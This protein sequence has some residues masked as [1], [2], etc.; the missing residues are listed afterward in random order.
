METAAPRSHP[1]T[2]PSPGSPSPPAIKLTSSI[3]DVP[4]VGAKRAAAFAKLGI[5][6]VA[7]L[8]R[9]IPARYEH[10]LSEQTIAAAGRSIGDLHGAEA[11][12]AVRGEVGAARAP[13]PGSRRAPFQATLFDGT[14][15]VKLTWFNA[16]WMRGKLHPGMNILV[17]GKAKRHGDYIEMVN[18]KWQP[19]NGEQQSRRSDRLVPVYPASEALPSAAIQQAVDHVLDP[20]LALLEDHLH[21][22]Y[23]RAA[24]L[25]ALADAYRMVHHP[26]DEEEI[27][28]GQ[29][30]LALDELLMLQ[31]GVMLKRHHRQRSLHAP[32]LR[33]TA[34]INQ[35]IRARFPFKLTAAQDSVIK[36]IVG[37][38]QR[39]TPMNRLIQ[40][41]VG[42]GKTIVALYAMLMARA[43][44]HQ[45]ALM[46][47]T[48]ILAE[49]HFQSMTQM[50]KGSRVTIE[51]L[52]GSLTPP[53]R[54]R[55][56]KGVE[57]GTIHILIGTHALLSGGVNF[58]SLALAVIDEQHR[59][60]VHQRATLRTKA[61]DPNSIP[62]TLVMTATPIP[63]TLSLT[64]FGDLDI[65]TIQGLPP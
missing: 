13:L 36:Q 50:L 4:G 22:A 10:Q 39:A 32:P 55:I 43:S 45:A 26:A 27:K 16:P 14:G 57:D 40:G 34:Q 37:D 35:R 25:P 15:T 44:G 7:D 41:D 30:R 21:E 38:L 5:R 52:T 3:A 63:R 54:R 29:R 23:R 56:H 59:F 62:H 48:E 12:I 64:I 6:S 47:P 42:S 49:Q 8:I 18:P 51:L 28:T 19:I 9:H 31:L 65:S 20:A 53:P 1:P 24:A 17:S 58:K 33:H 46:A 61:S 2:R 60:G 11:N